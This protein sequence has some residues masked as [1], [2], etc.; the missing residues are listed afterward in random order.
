MLFDSLKRAAGFRGAQVRERHA[1]GAPPCCLRASGA[2]AASNLAPA[3][4][5]CC[6]QAAA[7]KC[8]QRPGCAPATVAPRIW[9]AAVRRKRRPS[10]RPG[11]PRKARPRPRAQRSSTSLQEPLNVNCEP[12]T[13]GVGSNRCARLRALPRPGCGETCRKIA[14]DRAL[15][16]RRPPGG[17]PLRCAGAR[18]ASGCCGRRRP[19]PRGPGLLLP[20]L[21]DLLPESAGSVPANGVLIMDLFCPETAALSGWRGPQGGRESGG[22]GQR[23]ELVDLNPGRVR[24]KV[25]FAQRVEAHP[26]PLRDDQVIE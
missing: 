6:A 26:G 4:L 14:A 7:A 15:L 9:H 13:H 3:P 2:S 17:S 25:P 1:R 10:Y 8:Y 24:N 23:L 12:T 11:P 19:A 21:M 5:R 22:R 20:S 18:P 16:I